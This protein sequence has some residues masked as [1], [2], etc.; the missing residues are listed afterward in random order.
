MNKTNSTIEKMI[1]TSYTIKDVRDQVRKLNMQY[2]QDLVSETIEDEK[3]ER[4][5]VLSSTKNIKRKQIFLSLNFSDFETIIEALEL[6]IITR[7]ADYT[8]EGEEDLDS[9]IIRYEYLLL[10]A[11]NK[12][13]IITRRTEINIIISCIKDQLLKPL[14][15]GTDYIIDNDK[16]LFLKELINKLKVNN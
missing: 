2:K 4:D 15:I 12:S 1:K 10:K 5:L 9:G 16:I 13:V 3:N 8:F 14:E 6:A 7:R 11:K